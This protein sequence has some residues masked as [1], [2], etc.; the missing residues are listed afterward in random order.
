M[1]GGADR[2]QDEVLYERLLRASL[3]DPHGGAE[4]HAGHRAS[5]AYTQKDLER[6]MNKFSLRQLDLYILSI[7]IVI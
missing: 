2:L 6:L 3:G 5:T 7:V 1:V 4:G